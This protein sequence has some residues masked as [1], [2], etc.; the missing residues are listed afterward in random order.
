MNR[1]GNRDS[2]GETRHR[3]RPWPPQEVRD[4]VRGIENGGRAGGI[5]RGREKVKRCQ[6]RHWGNRGSGG[7][8]MKKV[9]DGI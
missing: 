1:M 7:L 5:C 6:A 3:R 2:V 9:G 8:R 4:G